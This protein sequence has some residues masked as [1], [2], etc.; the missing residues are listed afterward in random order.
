MPRRRSVS[1][2]LLDQ[3]PP[4]AIESERAILSEA[5][6]EHRV[7]PNAIV[8]PEHFS[9]EAHQT[10]WRVLNNLDAEHGRF[11]MAMLLA[12]LRDAKHPPGFNSAP[13]LGEL[14]GGDGLPSTIPFHVQQVRQAY[15][16]RTV[17]EAALQIF[18]AS[19]NG[20]IGPEKLREWSQR[21]TTIGGGDHEPDN[22][23]AFTR[24]LTSRE[25][26]DLDLKSNFL[27]RGVLVEGQP[28]VIG[29]RSKTLKTSIACDLA[30]SLASGRP[31]L[32]RFDAHQ[33]NVGFWSGE[34]GAAVVRET[35][36]RQAA[37]KGVELASCSVFWSF[38]LP[39]LTRIEHLDHLK[40]T[41]ERHALKVVIVDPLYLSLLDAATADQAGNLFAMGAALQPLTAMAQAA[42]VTLIVLHH[43]RKTG[44]SSDDEPAGLEELTMSGAAEWARQWIL[45][46]RR[47]AYQADGRHLL[48]MRCGGSAGHASLWGVTIDEGQLDPETFTGRTWDVSVAPVADARAEVKAAQENR[49]AAELEKREAEQRDRLLVV[50][51][52]TPNGETERVLSRAARL[53]Q[54]GFY[55][56]VTV[57]IQEGRAARCAVEKNGATYD[58]F[59]PTDR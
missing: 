14:A 49:K 48:W 9:L 11:D 8:R 19:H 37:A 46:Q 54:D 32:G 21:L 31:F 12:A 10:L 59:R 53:N 40:K 29:G 30:V 58:A 47:A 51:R 5:I 42:G 15:V 4:A 2:E 1:R 3:P 26:V 56:A 50:L 45:L 6:Q 43:F 33:V 36:K 25:F 18:R 38:D 23:P 22:A 7:N 41:I 39:K 35:A 52:Q 24:L 13:F 34:S 20:G 28:A 27:V 57:L 16:N 55:R 44:Q 17:G